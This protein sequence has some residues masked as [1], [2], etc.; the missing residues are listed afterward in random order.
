MLTRSPTGGIE[1]RGPRSET[2]L[3]NV[4]VLAINSKVVD[5]GSTGPAPDEKQGHTFGG[6]AIATLALDPPDADLVVSALAIGKLSL[7]LRPIEASDTGKTAKA[8]DSAN[9]AI[10]MSSPFWLK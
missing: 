8:Q 9:Q 1:S 3:R 4:R 5:A 10:R 2:I 7:L 6:Q